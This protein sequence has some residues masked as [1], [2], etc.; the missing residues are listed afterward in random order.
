MRS[1]G[2]ARLYDLLDEMPDIAVRLAEDLIRWLT[3]EECD[4]FAEANGYDDDDDD[5]DDDE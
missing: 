5:D 4:E 3:D 2:R 1:K